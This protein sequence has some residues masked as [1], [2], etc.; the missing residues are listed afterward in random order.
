MLHLGKSI[1]VLVTARVLQGFSASVVWIVGLALLADTV[2]TEEIGQAM[3]YVYLAMS[4]GL[5]LGPLLGGVIFDKAGY[6]AVFA[7]AYAIVAVDVALRLVAVEKKVARKWEEPEVAPGTELEQRDGEETAAPDEGQLIPRTGRKAPSVVTLLK[8][9]RMLVSL[10][11]SIVMA[12][13]MTSLDAVLPLYV[14][15]TFEWTSLGA[16]T[17]PSS[18][19]KASKTTETNVSNKVFSSSRSSSHP[20]SAQSSATS[21]TAWAQ[22][23]SPPPVSSWPS[24]SGRS[25][26]S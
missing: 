22:N 14:R 5:L 4:M 20:S 19:G 12:T 10:W 1:A 18:T 2:P 13:L 11:C 16:G 9:T 15:A 26:A 3:G 24:R 21:P 6:D 8:S 23:G 17:I 7:V 25:S